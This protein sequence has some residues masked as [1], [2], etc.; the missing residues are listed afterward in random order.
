MSMLD[1]GVGGG[2]T[3]LHFANLVRSYTGID[4]SAAMIQACKRRFATCPATWQFDVC[5][6]KSMDIFADDMF[7]FVLFSFNGIDCVPYSERSKALSEMMRVCKKGGYICFSTHNIRGIDRLRQ[8]RMSAHP[9]TVKY[10]I[11]RYLKIRLYNQPL[12]TRGRTQALKGEVYAV[13][14][15]GAENFRTTCSYIRPEEQVRQ[16][17]A[18]GFTRIRTFGLDDGREI[19]EVSLSKREDMWIYYLCET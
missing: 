5:D 4:Y 13:I 9:G 12:R 1:I 15:D 6:V 7:D 3:T 17:A 16:L 14:R 8:F 10:E 2:R 18:L 19:D 11:V